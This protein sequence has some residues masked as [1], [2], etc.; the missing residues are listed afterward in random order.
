MATVKQS[1]YQRRYY[2]SRR[3]QRLAKSLEYQRQ[4][5]DERK[6][7]MRTYYAKNKQAKWGKRTKEQRAKINR[8]RRLK[9][10]SDEQWR[11]QHKAN[12]KDWQRRNQ[13]KRF[14]QRLRPF[15]IT[16]EQYRGMLAAQSGGCAI[17]GAVESPDKS[18]RSANGKRRLHIDHCHITNAVRG[19]LCSQCN[20]GLGKFKDNPTLLERAAMYLRAS[21]RAEGDR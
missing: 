16:P 8:A 18:A 19:L 7:Y 12:V 9:Y 17:C 14:A 20:L 6:V 4:H 15:G 1:A 10:A 3:E 2:R 13:D 5:A 11:E 21:Q